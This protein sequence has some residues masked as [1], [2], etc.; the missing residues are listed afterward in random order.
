LEELQ[1]LL[2]L[3]EMTVESVEET[4]LR[5]VKKGCKISKNEPAFP[6]CYVKDPLA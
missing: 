5:L 1:R 2:H 3:L 6:G 4:K